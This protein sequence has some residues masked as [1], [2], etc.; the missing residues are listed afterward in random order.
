[1]PKEKASFSRL[2]KE[3]FETLLADTLNK[4]DGP[5]KR[6]DEHSTYTLLEVPTTRAGIERIE[7]DWENNECDA[8]EA[9]M[10]CK[11]AGI[12][13]LGPLT[14]LGVT[15]GGD[16]ETPVFSIFYFDK[17][18]NLCAYIPEKGNVYNFL[19][20][21]AYGNNEYGSNSDEKASRMVYKKS[22]QEVD[23]YRDDA[24]LDDIRIHFGIK[25]SEV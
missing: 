18:Q 10:D 12:Q 11:I 25:K 16:W 8:A 21:A 4:F 5:F 2:T 13:T 19:A 1:M 6:W 14:F 7:H 22:Y 24:M 17:D 15:A 9:F 3:E 20:K 23:T